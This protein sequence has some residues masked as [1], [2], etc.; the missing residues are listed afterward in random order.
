MEQ[1]LMMGI[2]SFNSRAHEGR[3]RK[4]SQT[5]RVMACFNS[6]AHEGRDEV[7]FQGFPAIES[8]N[9]RAHEGRDS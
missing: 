1:L 6:R 7:R 3:D 5:S 4:H 2:K 9:S 8:F